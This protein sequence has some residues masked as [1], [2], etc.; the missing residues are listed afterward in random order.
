[1]CSGRIDLEFILRSFYNGHDGVFLG[2]CRLGECNYVTQGNF[3][4]L[5]NYLIS[6]KILEHLGLNPERIRIEFMNASDGILLANSITDF[7]SQVEELGPLGKGEGID[8]DMLRFNLAAIRKLV[9]WMRLVERER[10]RV[11]LKSEKAFR[12]FYASEEFDRLFKE[13]VLDKLAMSQITSLLRDKPQSTSEIAEALGLNP[14][15]VSRHM[16]TSSRHG[17]VR[18]DT[19]QQ[20]YALA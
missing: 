15:E 4:A 2:G 5:A 19:E 17:L 3:D 14:S 7:S 16:N 1:M 13:L 12:E 20:L 6:R 9:P 18:Y 10:F 8:L 11:P